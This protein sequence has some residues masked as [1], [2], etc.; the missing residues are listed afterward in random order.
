MPVALAWPGVLV[1]CS[2]VLPL[3]EATRLNMRWIWLPSAVA[4]PQ[5][6]APALTLLAVP[7]K[8]AGSRAPPGS[9][10]GGL[11]FNV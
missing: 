11:F 6:E 4:R 2:A 10:A 1:G 7:G 5:D 3:W 9:D 8:P